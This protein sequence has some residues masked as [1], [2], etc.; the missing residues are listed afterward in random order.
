MKMARLDIN[1]YRN[2]LN[3]LQKELDI[4]NIKEQEMFEFIEDKYNSIENDDKALYKTFC[5]LRDHYYLNIEEKMF[6]SMMLLLCHIKTEQE[7]I[8]VENNKRNFKSIVE[9][10]DEDDEEDYDDD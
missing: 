10:D 4:P 9:N 3:Y 7:R 6:A 8:K 2:Y 5:K 1:N